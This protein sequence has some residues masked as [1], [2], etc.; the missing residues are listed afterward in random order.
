MA[1]SLAGSR[2]WV[3]GATGGLGQSVVAHLLAHGAQ[4]CA[5]GR[6]AAIGERLTQLDAVFEALDLTSMSRDDWLER[7][8]S[9]DTIVHCAALSSPWGAYEDFYAINVLATQTLLEAA[10]RAG[11]RRFIHI[12]TPSLYFDFKHQLNIAED[13]PLP[14]PINA[15]AQTKREAEK[16]VQHWASQGLNCVIIRPRAIFGPHDTVLMPRLLRAYRNGR[17]PLIAGGQALID[18]TYVDN[19]AQAIYLAVVKDLDFSQKI[20]K[21]YNISNNQPMQLK[22]ILSELFA[23]LNQP[24]QFKNLPWWLAIGLAHILQRLGKWRGKEPLLM[25][26]T[27]GT[28]AFSQTLNITRAQQEL[29]YAPSISIEE[30][31]GRYIKWARTEE[32]LLRETDA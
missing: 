21:I 27:V 13:M 29:G 1:Y 11:V 23:Q 19:V 6:N 20:A 10:H 2:V 8:H 15:Y 32:P 22:A 26:Y 31:I 25:P 18:I 30:G 12:S 17:M 28:M 9:G 4:V 16:Q 24:V 14:M 3:T 5:T 7:L